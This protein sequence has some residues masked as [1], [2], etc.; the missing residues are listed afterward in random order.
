[1]KSNN[2]TRLEIYSIAIALIVCF[3]YLKGC[4]EPS[5][6]GEIVKIGGK[7]YE[8]IDKKTDTFYKT[9]TKVV[10]KKGKDI[11][12]E[13]EVAR[14]KEV[15]VKVDT[16]AI[17]K[18]YYSRV[19]YRDTF[20]L[21]DTLGYFV[22]NDTVTQNR[23]S[24]RKIETSLNFPTVKETIYLKELSNDFYLG[25]FLQVGGSSISIGAD[26]H[27]KTKKEM[28]FGLGAGVNSNASPFLRGS[29]SWKINK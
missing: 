5:K 25:P 26:A 6:K 24:S 22:I 8:V 13:I 21:K 11:F 7:D 2:I 3:M 12:H 14:I 4:F 17:L 29:V 27:L 23:I 1:M 19:F 20:K 28:L 9:E 15:P 16:S 18:D 10:Y